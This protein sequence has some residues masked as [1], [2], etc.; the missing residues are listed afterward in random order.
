MIGPEWGPPIDWDEPLDAET[1]EEMIRIQEARRIEDEIA[2]RRSRVF[3]EEYA[4]YY[5]R[6]GR[7]V[8]VPP[9]PRT[10]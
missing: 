4:G 3:W 5:G 2:E 9:K 10:D 6:D 8:I 1:S 7:L